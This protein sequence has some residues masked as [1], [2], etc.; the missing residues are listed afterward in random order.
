MQIYSKKS[1]SLLFILPA[2]ILCALIFC[3]KTNHLDAATLKVSDIPTAFNFS[4]NLKQGDSINPDVAYLQFILDQ[5]GD[6]QVAASGPGSLDDITNYFGSKTKLAVMNFQ[7]KFRNDILTPANIPKPTGFVGE[8]TRAKLNQILGILLSGSYSE[9]N[10]FAP[11][12][13]AVSSSGISNQSNAYTSNL[14]NSTASGV[15]NTS[16]SST[17]NPANLPLISSFSTF[18]AISGQFMSLFGAQFHPTK[19]TVYLGSENIGVYPS[20]DNGTKIT[21]KV[22]PTLETGSYEAGVANTYGTTSTGYM[23]LNVTKP[24]ISSTTPIISFTPSLTTIYPNTSKNLNDLVFLYGENFSFNNTLETNL[25]NT[26]V[27]STDR[28]TLSFLIGE[29]PYYMDAFKK[30][31]NQSINVLIKLRNENGLSKEQLVH[32]INFP[33]SGTPTVNTSLQAA[34]PSFDTS[35]TTDDAYETAY[36]R[37]AESTAATNNSTASS[38]GS[39]SGSSGDSGESSGSSLMGGMSDPSSMLDSAK[40]PADPLLEQLRE[41]SPVH[42]FITDP[43]VK[44]GSNPL[45]SLTGGGSSSG[46]GAALGGA[47][48]GSGGSS[49]GSSM[50]DFGGTI[51]QATVCTCS[52]GLP[53]LLSIR[54]VRGNTIQAMYQPGLSS[55]KENYNIWTP[56][57]STLGGMYSGGQSCQ[58][59]VSPYCSSQGTAQ[60]TIDF[61]RGIGTSLVPAGK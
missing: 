60:Y 11:L 47:G 17:V 13:D 19:N 16:T 33:N 5:S 56:N 39:G 15:V 54:D 4:K 55:L 35:S 29:L 8:R 43:L 50:T 25:G 42:K 61:I 18:K 58:V 34:P 22:P 23:Y 44:G 52:I 24:E 10:I 48:G 1:K 30:Y 59:G 38:S 7:E 40:P 2:S 51:T 41:V 36:R 57:V 9:S 20:L 32:V 53:T 37:Q 21:F 27:R 28:K 3:V 45:S 26:V 12:P 6:T 14:S 49:G 46:G 31:K